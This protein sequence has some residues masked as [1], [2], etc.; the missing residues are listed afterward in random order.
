M[1]LT[2]STSWSL[3]LRRKAT[4]LNEYE[5]ATV[6][7]MR[8]LS[9]QN[10]LAI[11]IGAVRQEVLSGIKHVEQFDKVKEVL[12]DYP[13]LIP[14]QADYIAAAQMFNK[15]RSAGIQGSTTDFLIC[16]VAWRLNCPI[17]TSDRDFERYAPIVGIPL[18]RV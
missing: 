1:I 12:E 5:K 10:Q 4:S 18:Y 6:E 8:I 16:A 15:C 17:L 11:I 14:I 3:Y 2:D 9:A 13:D 7:R